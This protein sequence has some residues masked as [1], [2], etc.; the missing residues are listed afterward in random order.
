MENPLPTGPLARRWNSTS[1]EILLLSLMSL[2]DLGSSV[3]SNSLGEALCAAT[4]Y[5]RHS[6]MGALMAAGASTA[7]ADGQGNTALS[8]ACKCGSVEAAAM[9]LAKGADPEHSNH[10]GDSPS[11]L[12]QKH[13]YVNVLGLALSMVESQELSEL[14]GDEEP[15]KRR[16]RPRI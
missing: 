3:D 16:R 9:L 14:L 8:Y 13:H 10:D 12:S 5:G 4:K 7:Y 1:V 6:D 15:N 11:Y 2:P